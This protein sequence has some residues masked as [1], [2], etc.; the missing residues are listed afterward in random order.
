MRS[1]NICFMRD[2]WTERCSRPPRYRAIAYRGVAIVVD[3]PCRTLREAQEERHAMR[4]SGLYDRAAILNDGLE[5][6]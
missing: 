3:V 2:R 6:E 4:K 5:V 1:V